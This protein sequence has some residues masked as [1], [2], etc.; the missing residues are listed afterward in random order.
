MEVSKQLVRV[1][2]L[3]DFKVGLSAAA[4]SHRIC[5][6]FG[7]SAVNERSLRHW[8]LKFRS[9]EVS[10]ADEP[11]SG[12]P[13][14]LD[15]EALK[16]A[17]VEDSGLTCDELAERFHVSAETVRLHLHGIGKS[18]RVS[19]WVPHTLSAANK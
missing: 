18:Y 19:K 13:H 16:A 9:G 14:V 4:S 5:Q 11:R 8:F 15:D 6:A 2:L 1:C 10:L 7:E 12:G 17:I 3:Y